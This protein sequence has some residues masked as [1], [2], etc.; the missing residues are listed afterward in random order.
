MIVT[1]LACPLFIDVPTSDLCQKGSKLRICVSLRSPHLHQPSR[2]ACLRETGR[3]SGKSILIS[4]VIRIS[5][6]PPNLCLFA[7]LVILWHMET[8]RYFF[9]YLRLLSI[10]LDG[11]VLFATQL[12]LPE[13]R[14]RTFCHPSFLWLFLDL[15]LWVLCLL[16]VVT[17]AFLGLKWAVLPNTNLNQAFHSTE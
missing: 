10:F 9:F 12:I 7:V 6:I 17:S 14:V 4:L 2:P 1:I 13:G 11:C 5:V 8:S 16:F 15:S 3:M